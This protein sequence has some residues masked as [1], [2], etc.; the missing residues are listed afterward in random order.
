MCTVIY[1]N[2]L[3]TGSILTRCLAHV[4]NLATQATLAAYS[5]AK[6]YNPH[7]PD[8]HV[9]GVSGDTDR[10]EVGLVRA[11]CVKVCPSTV[12]IDMCSLIRLQERSS[13]KR[14]QLF[15]EIQKARG[16]LR[17]VTLL[18]DMPVRWSSTYVMLNRAYGSRE[19]RVS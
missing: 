3:L 9:L 16:V 8:G 18:L 7:D 2:L 10:D 6:Y 17:P 14:K 13:S 12:D 4:I 5:S 1:T 11:I 15:Y 19:V